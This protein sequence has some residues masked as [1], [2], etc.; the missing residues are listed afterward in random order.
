MIF[1]VISEMIPE[2]RDSES[3]RLSSGLAGIGGFLLMMVLQNV[4]VF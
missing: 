1:L 4:L 3:Q 2:S